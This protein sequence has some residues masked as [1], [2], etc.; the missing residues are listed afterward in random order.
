MVKQLNLPNNASV[1][2]VV[3]AYDQTLSIG[4][5]LANVPTKKIQGV[6]P[7]IISDLYINS[8]QPREYP[9]KIDKNTVA[10]NS[11]EYMAYSAQK[12]KAG[13][14]NNDPSF[15]A[16]LEAIKTGNYDGYSQSIMDP[17]GY[18]Q[19]RNI[20]KSISQYSY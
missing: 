5:K 4:M 19:S 2:Q 9:F 10:N 7:L 16:M 18:K 3:G 17:K 8:I 6:V 14:V 15:A 1:D 12:L 20:S 13:L 11:S